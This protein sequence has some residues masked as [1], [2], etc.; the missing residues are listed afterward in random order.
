MVWVR[1]RPRPEKFWVRT[2]TRTLSPLLAA[3][4]T[5]RALAGLREKAT[6]WCWLE[7]AGIVPM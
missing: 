2:L 4:R 6:V 1:T 3:S 7:S 5:S